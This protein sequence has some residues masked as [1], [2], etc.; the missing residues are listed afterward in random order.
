MI[1]LNLAENITILR[2]KRGVT[3]DELAAFLNVTKASVSKWETKQSYPDILLLPQIAA[4]FNISI[5][6][7]LGYQPQMSPEQIKKCYLDL[8]GDFARLPFNEVMEKSRILVKEY[9]SCYPLLM[10][11]ANLWVN[12]YMLTPDQEKQTGILRD[13]IELC[14]HIRENSGEVGT[15]SNAVELKAAVNLLLGNAKE[16]IEELEPLFDAKQF[17]LQSDPILIQAYRMTGDLSKATLCSQITIYSYLLSLVS[18]SLGMMNLQI[19][20]RDTCEQTIHKIRQL[21]EAYDLERLHPNI[22]L[23]FHYLSAVF[24]CAHGET[25]KALKELEQFVLGSLDFIENG[26]SLHGDAYFDRI[27][28]WFDQFTLKTEAPRNKKVV[29][30][31]L[32]PAMESPALSVLFDTGKYQELK[33]KI[34]QKQEGV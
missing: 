29:L 7:L 17:T 21:V 4:F 8:A 20:D 33:K 19:E 18:N 15:C 12:H 3:Q 27:E 34:E 25:E 32:I 11:I 30:D 16:T 24:Y 9:Y 22:T 23:Q 2:R 6:D 13:V 28:E 31:S 26:L 14:D 5:D 10:Q 1:R